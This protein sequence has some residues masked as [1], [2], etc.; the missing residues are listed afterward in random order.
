MGLGMLAGVLWLG[1]LSGCAT[2]SEGEI[3]LAA[4]T[5][6]SLM[7]REVQLPPVQSFESADGTIRAAAAGKLSEPLEQTET[8]WYGAFDIGSDG[9][10][11]CVF[12][13][14]NVDAATA[15]KVHV[16]GF[17]ETLR[18]GVQAEGG[19][20]VAEEQKVLAAVFADLC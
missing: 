8:G 17:V 18:E 9:A 19:A 13:S 14:Q 10:V 20:E 5:F 3:A 15:V 11:N 16:A 7:E 1:G 2:P 6:E 12:Y 4:P